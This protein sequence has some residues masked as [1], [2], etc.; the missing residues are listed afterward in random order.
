VKKNMV[1]NNQTL[2]FNIV[3]ALPNGFII[4]KKFQISCPQEVSNSQ[5]K[6][7]G[8]N[9]VMHDPLNGNHGT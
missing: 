5:N 9:R 3:A 6:F 1:Y 8:H 4:S 7:S 2:I